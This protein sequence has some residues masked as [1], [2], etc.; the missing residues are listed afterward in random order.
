MALTTEHLQRLQRAGLDSFFTRE[1]S[2]FRPLAYEAYDY[3]VTMVAPT[4]QPVHV[5]DAAAPL[6][7]ALN[8]N[9]K[10]ADYL[11]A[12]RLTQKYWTEWFADY[13]LDQLWADLSTRSAGPTRE[14]SPRRRSSRP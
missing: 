4:G 8:L 12:K 5:D 3:A 9:K 7:L 11:A 10:L 13:I 14:A 1:Q 2:V 6:R